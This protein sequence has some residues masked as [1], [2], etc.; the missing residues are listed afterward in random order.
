MMASK[1]S[2]DQLSCEFKVALYTGVS[3]VTRS[4]DFDGHILRRLKSARLSCN[5]F[6]AWVESLWYKLAISSVSIKFFPDLHAER[7]C[8]RLRSHEDNLTFIE[9]WKSWSSKF[10]SWELLQHCRLDVKT[11]EKLSCPIVFFCEKKLS[12]CFLSQTAC[13]VNC[14]RNLKYASLCSLAGLRLSNPFKLKNKNY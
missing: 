8:L 6:F 13:G 7:W 12:S 9:V 3:L 2:W 10:Q 4:N 11:S 5:L 14:M 1:Y